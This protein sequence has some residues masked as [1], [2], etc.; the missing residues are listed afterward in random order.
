MIE[1]SYVKV[2][3]MI[4]SSAFD[5]ELTTVIFVQPLWWLLFL[6]E[7]AARPLIYGVPLLH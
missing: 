4:D 7:R 5:M 3:S 6:D 2:V 1:F